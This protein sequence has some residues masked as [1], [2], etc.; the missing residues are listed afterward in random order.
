M[1]KPI[2]TWA[3]AAINR[4]IEAGDFDYADSYRFALKGDPAS[5]DDFDSRRTCCG[6]EEWEET[7]PDGKVYLLGF[8]YGH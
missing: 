8:N 6:C 3:K 7:G 2:K 1:K 5:M 4:R